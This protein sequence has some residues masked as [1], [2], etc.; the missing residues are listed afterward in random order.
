M[1][2]GF[3]LALSVIATIREFIGN[4]SVTLWGKIALTDIHNYGIILF[5]CA[6]A[7]A[8]TLGLILAG[9]NHIQA[10]A[11]Q[12]QGQPPPAPVDFDCR[13]CTVCTISSDK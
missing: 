4:G 11:A 9:I 10:L 7:A 5:V 8:I 12:K 13:H 1:G 2:L 6:A 3:T